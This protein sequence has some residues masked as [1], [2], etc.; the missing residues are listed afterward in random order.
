MARANAGRYAPGFHL[1]E[2]HQARVIVLV[3]LEG[4]P[5]A[6]DGI[7]DE[8]DR[9]VVVDGFEGLEQARNIVAGEIGHQ[10]RQGIVAAPLDEAG[11]GPLVADLVVET[12][13][14]G[15]SALIGERRKELVRAS[16]DPGA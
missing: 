15:R 11:D 5:R 7:G 3:A 2:S 13:A 12:P 8:A 10:L 16:I 4:K 14:P 1:L 9:P 6:L